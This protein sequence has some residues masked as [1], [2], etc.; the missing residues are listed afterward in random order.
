MTILLTGATGFMGRRIVD[1]LLLAGEPVR[2]L[3]R[4][5]ATAGLPDGVELFAGDLGQPETI[6]D[7]LR[8]VDRMYLVPAAPETSEEVV[9]LARAAGVRRMVVLSG[10][11]AD[12]DAWGARGYLAVER[13]AERSG[14]EW[15]HVRPGEFAG[16][17]LGWAPSVRAERLVRRPYGNA[18]TQPVHE[19]DVA[20]VIAATLIREGHAGVTYTFAGPEALTTV[21]QVGLI[22]AALGEEVRFEEDDPV[23]AREQWIRDGYPAVFVDWMF[24]VWARSAREPAPVNEE[25]AAVVPRLTGRPARTFAQWAVDHA[26]SFR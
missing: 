16:N 20:A 24:E 13:A 21:E 23:Q 6:R 17:W 4:T 12:D 10:A 26:A 11:A 3:T 18:V 7:A 2:A 19:S 15:T 1:E 8:S 5:P 14:L 25:W 9:A 22:G